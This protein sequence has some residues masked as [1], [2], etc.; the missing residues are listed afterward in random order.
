MNE[1]EGVRLIKMIENATIVFD[2]SSIGML[3]HL[4]EDSKKSMLQILSEYF[5]ERI[6]LTSRVWEEYTRHKK[7]FITQLI[8]EYYS[9]P[10]FLQSKNHTYF[11]SL[12]SFVESLKKQSDYHPAFSEQYIK[13]ITELYTELVSIANKIRIKTEGQLNQ[14]IEDIRKVSEGSDCV[15]DSFKQFR[16][17]ENLSYQD[18]LQIVKEGDIRYEH[19]IPPG[20]MDEGKESI[21]KFGDLIIWKEVLDFAKRNET[22]IIFITNDKKPDWYANSEK[23]IPREELIREFASVSHKKIGILPLE[24]FISILKKKFPLSQDRPPLWNGIE[25]IHVELEERKNAEKVRSQQAITVDCLDCKKRVYYDIDEIEPEWHCEDV[26]YGKH[27]ERS[28]TYQTSLWLNCPCCGTDHEIDIQVTRTENRNN[29]IECT[30]SNNCIVKKVTQAV[31]DSITENTFKQCQRCGQWFSESEL[32]ESGFC[33]DC[34]DY[35]MNKD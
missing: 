26:S 14:R 30:S 23:N 17:A 21:D 5:G 33:S 13:E 6:W 34:E 16:K 3:Y 11:T 20:Y 22:D 28:T 24:E 4:T 10:Q 19:R 1:Y 27:G 32:S 9:T 35:Y 8:R 15:Y 18:I 2:T 29:D 25:Q 12:K 7:R 31:V